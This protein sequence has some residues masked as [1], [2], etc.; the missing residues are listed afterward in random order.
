MHLLIEHVSIIPT[1]QK[2]L[3]HSGKFI[4]ANDFKGL[5]RL[6][7]EAM[8]AVNRS[9]RD[10]KSK[11]SR[12]TSQLENLKD[13]LTRLWVGS[14]PLVTMKRSKGLPSYNLCKE[15]DHDRSSCKLK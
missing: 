14:D 8:E 3:A 10:I 15:I 4:R 5:G 11:L 12:K 1:L 7:N 9:L 2:L 13:C 6:L